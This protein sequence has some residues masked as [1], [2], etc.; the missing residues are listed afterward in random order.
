[1]KTVRAFY[2]HGANDPDNIVDTTCN[3][4]RALIKEKAAKSGR[5]IKV[6]VVPGRDDFR[7]NCRGDW[8]AWGKS[9][10]TRRDAMTQAVFYDFIVLPGLVVGRATAQIVDYAVRAGRPVFMLVGMAANPDCL[11]RVTQ[12]YPYDPDDWQGG[13]RCETEGEQKPKP[14]GDA[15]LELPLKYKEPPSGKE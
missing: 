13:F 15:Q 6:S 3:Q 8:E 12:V 1:M 2:A 11:L 7:I 9:I 10:I 14:K 5:E 4:V